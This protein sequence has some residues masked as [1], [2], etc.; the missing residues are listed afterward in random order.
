MHRVRT[1]PFPVK[2]RG[3]Q[4]GEGSGWGS[5]KQALVLPPSVMSQ[6]LRCAL[7]SLSDFILTCKLAGLG[8]HLNAKSTPLSE[9]PQLA[10]A[11]ESSDL[12]GHNGPRDIWW[13]SQRRNH[14]QFISTQSQGL[15]RVKT[16]RSRDG[17]RGGGVAG[18]WKKCTCWL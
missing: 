18:R 11:K 13:Q 12:R 2:E 14:Y 6:G 7:F 3:L 15:G 4:H 10:V 5:G 1:A 16:V 17:R 9:V 8:H